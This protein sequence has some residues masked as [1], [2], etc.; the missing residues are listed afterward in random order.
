MPSSM[1]IQVALTQLCILIHHLYHQV[2]L[3]VVQISCTVQVVVDS[4][5][6]NMDNN[7]IKLYIEQNIKSQEPG[8]GTDP[9]LAL[10]LSH[11]TASLCLQTQTLNRVPT[12][13]QIVQAWNNWKLERITYIQHVRNFTTENKQRLTSMAADRVS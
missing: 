13:D 5:T 1:V 10:E 2:D 3:Y 9:R 6:D 4:L 12:H 11:F 8:L 7:Q